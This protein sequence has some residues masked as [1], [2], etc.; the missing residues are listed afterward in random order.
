MAKKIN[1]FAI[2]LFVLGAL[3]IFTTTLILLFGGNFFKNKASFVLYFNGSVN[4]LDVGSAV[5]F[6]GVRIGNVKSVDVVYDAESDVILTPIIIEINAVIFSP[7]TNLLPKAERKD[8]Y[9]HQ[10]RNGLAA[11]LGMESFV[12]G[13]LFIEL[14]Y[15]RLNKPRFHRKNGTNFIAIP[16]IT[17]EIDKF[18]SGADSLIK[19]FDQIDFK[20]ISERLMSILS[21]LDDQIQDSNISEM[22][23]NISNAALAIQSFLNSDRMYGLLEDASVAMGDLQ[24]FLGKLSQAVERLETD[25]AVTT[26]AMRRVMS[27]DIG[28][29]AS[30]LHRASEKFAET[31]ASISELLGSQSDFRESAKVFLSQ[32]SKAIQ[33]LRYFLDL[34]NKAPNAIVAGVDYETEH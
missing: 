25:V 22:I 26:K 2:G 31:C 19:K 11:K 32:G 28:R 6:K 10:I 16:T 23:Q 3:A 13:K 27:E 18:I 30:D 4:G 33:S 1:P 5:K 12:T 20:H 7:S 24:G 21:N 29:V 17:S 15:H 8:F 34:L 9:D 14:D